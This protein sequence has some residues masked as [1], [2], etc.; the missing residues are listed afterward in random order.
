MEYNDTNGVLNFS[1]KSLRSKIIPLVQ[2][3]APSFF[4]NPIISLKVSFGLSV[5]T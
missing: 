2:S 4:S 3:I 1:Y 5:V